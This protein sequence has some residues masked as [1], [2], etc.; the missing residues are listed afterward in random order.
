MCR[1]WTAFARKRP[2]VGRDVGDLDE[3]RSS[4][5]HDYAASAAPSLV[6]TMGKRWNYRC[7]TIVCERAIPVNTTV[8]GWVH[9]S[10]PNKR[11][12]RHELRSVLSFVR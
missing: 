11:T 8:S 1:W 10:M 4:E 9:E 12:C 6:S 7:T 2:Q 5:V 3:S